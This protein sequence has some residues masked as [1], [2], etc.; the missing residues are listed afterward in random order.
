MKT[1]AKLRI[2]FKRQLWNGVSRGLFS[3]NMEGVIFANLLQINSP[4]SEYRS[5]GSAKCRTIS[6]F[7]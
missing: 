1:T 5:I 6:R 2:C 4:S 7:P 3:K